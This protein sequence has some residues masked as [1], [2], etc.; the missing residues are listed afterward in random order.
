MTKKTRQRVTEKSVKTDKKFLAWYDDNAKDVTILQAYY[1]YKNKITSV[2]TCTCGNGVRFMNQDVGFRSFCSNTCRAKRSRTTKPFVEKI[3]GN[4]KRYDKINFETVLLSKKEYDPK[5]DGYDK[6]VAEN[7]IPTI[8]SLIKKHIPDFIY[9]EET[10]LSNSLLDRIRDRSPLVYSDGVFD[11]GI[12]NSVGN[13]EL[14]S[15][16]HSFYRSANGKNMSVV[17][18]YEKGI[19]LDKVLRYRMGLNEIGE[20]WDL[21][22]KNI[23]KGYSAVRGLVSFF[24]PSVAASIYSNISGRNS[25]VFDPCMGFGGRM[26]GYFSVRRDGYYVGCEPNKETFSELCILR[27]RLIGL[28][29]TG[30]ITLYNETVEEFV[31]NHLRSHGDIELTFTSI[32][33]Y[34]AERY[35]QD[36]IGKRYKDFDDWK[37]KF[38][39][40]LHRLPNCWINLPVELSERLVMDTSERYIMRNNVAGHL[41]DKKYKDEYIVRLT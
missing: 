1:M 41:S 23:V 24:K 25:V 9:P 27:D 20:C 6:T 17:E 7:S 11:N 3:L 18:K 13:R 22:F 10:V 4:I 40:S 36:V 39:S 38:V 32:P 26:L 30:T 5:M 34:D 14:K 2:P 29:I 35:S 8:T 16:F 31:D 19:G 21:S 28:G 12:H 15:I 37:E 33:Y